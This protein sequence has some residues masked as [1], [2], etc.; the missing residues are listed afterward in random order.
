MVNGTSLHLNDGMESLN[1]LLTKAKTGV[2]PRLKDLEQSDE[3][4]KGCV[5][6][7]EEKLAKVVTSDK[8]ILQAAPSLE[9]A[10]QELSSKIDKVA[11]VLHALEGKLSSCSSRILYN[12]QH[13]Q[14]NNFKISG[15]LFVEGEDPLLAATTFFKGHYGNYG[16]R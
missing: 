5:L 11:Q 14:A 8:V 12:T 10:Q 16:R 9:V 1:G 3:K 4:M 13:N 15:I 2:I 6:T 7:L